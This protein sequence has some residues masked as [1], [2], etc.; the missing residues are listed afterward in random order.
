ME[1]KNCP[2]CG[3][4]EDGVK[5]IEQEKINNYAGRVVKYRVVCIDCGLTTP[6]RT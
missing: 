2:C 5:L 6:W 1:I 4:P 3:I